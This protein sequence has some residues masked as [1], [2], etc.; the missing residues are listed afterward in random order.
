MERISTHS[1]FST[2]NPIVLCP[3]N[4]IPGSIPVKIIVIDVTGK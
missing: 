3:R 1:F 2:S 4:I